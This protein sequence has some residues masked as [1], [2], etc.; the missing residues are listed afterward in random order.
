MLDHSPI[1]KGSIEVLS[2]F[3]ILGTMLDWLPSMAA[4]LSVAWYLYSFYQVWKDRGG[5][6]KNLG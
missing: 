4:G 6:H 3:V 2:V 1:I 5:K